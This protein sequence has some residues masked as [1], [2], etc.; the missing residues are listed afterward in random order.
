VQK[1]R[2]IYEGGRKASLREEE[3]RKILQDVGLI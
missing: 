1:V 3:F 2:E